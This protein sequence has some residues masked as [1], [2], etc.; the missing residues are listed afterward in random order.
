MNP[1]YHL[2]LTTGQD[3]KV[4]KAKLQSLK[5]A[6]S[7]NFTVSDFLSLKTSTG[8]IIT[9]ITMLNTASTNRNK[10]TAVS[11]TSERGEIDTY[12]SL[13][14]FDS[15]DHGRSTSGGSFLVDT[16]SY[17]SPINV[18]FHEAPLNSSLTVASKTIIS[19]IEVSLPRTFEG[20]FFSSSGINLPPIG[21]RDLIDDPS[22]QNRTAVFNWN[23][24]RTHGGL[25]GLGGLM[26]GDITWGSEETLDRGLVE[27]KSLLFHPL[28]SVYR[29]RPKV[30][31]HYSFIDRDS[32]LQMFRE[33]EEED[34]W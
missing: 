29:P 33:E 10:P 21:V 19:P 6:I 2:G 3:V 27:L 28:V 32:I 25:L 9:N 12:L 1:I 7:G 23:S 13:F 4:E 17:T 26:S 34:E 15:E 8:A 24:T 30:G 20:R 14:T 11:V 22:G 31:P 5:G 16:R 18:K